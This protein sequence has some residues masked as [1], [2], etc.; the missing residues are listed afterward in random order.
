V[1]KGHRHV[2]R[3]SQRMR[4]IGAKQVF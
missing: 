3:V 4:V 1:I 2:I